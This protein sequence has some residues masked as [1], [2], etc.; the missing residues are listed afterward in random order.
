MLRKQELIVIYLVFTLCVTLFAEEMRPVARTTSPNVSTA[1]PAEREV[2]FAPM[3]SLPAARTFTAQ[4]PQTGETITIVLPEMMGD[5]VQFRT[6]TKTNPE[7][8]KIER[9]LMPV[10]IE[11]PVRPA[12]RTVTTRNP[13]TGEFVQMQVPIPAEDP[14]LPMT[15]SVPRRN[16]ETGETQRIQVPVRTAA[17]RTPP[18]VVYCSRCGMIP[19]QEGTKCPATNSSHDFVKAETGKL[20]LCS[21]CG[22]VPSSAGTKCPVTNA[23]HNFKEY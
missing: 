23:G 21:H 12:A 15:R 4:N 9:I 17:T 3:I 13:E 6:I 16:P 18:I 2:P 22:A 11:D 14:V 1:A 8:G 5:R 10:A 7:S 20:L 19:H